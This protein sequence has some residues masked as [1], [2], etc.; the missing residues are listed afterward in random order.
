[1]C[2]SETWK[3]VGSLEISAALYL[4]EAIEQWLPNIIP[5]S[6]IIQGYCLDFHFLKRVVIDASPDCG[7]RSRQ[8]LY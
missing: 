2:V 3:V 1:M 8:A 5:L 6:V 7:A 4:G